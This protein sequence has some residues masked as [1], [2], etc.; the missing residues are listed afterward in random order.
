MML[1]TLTSFILLVFFLLFVSGLLRAQVREKLPEK[2]SDQSDWCINCHRSITPG[3]VASWEKSVHSRIS[4][5]EAMKKEGLKRKV[6]AEQLPED[7]KSVVVGCYECHG[8]RGEEHSDHFDHHGASIN[9]IVSP[10]DCASC[11]PVEASQF[12]ESKKAHA[13]DNLVKNEVFEQ[14][15]EAVI[16][17]SDA[18]V[19]ASTRRYTCEACHGS[20]VSVTGTRVVKR[21]MPVELP[22]LSNWPN[23]G[24]GRINPDG[25]RGACTA[26]HPRHSFSIE[27]ARKPHTCSQ[28]HLA[29]DF[30]AWEVYR[31]SKHGNI[32]LSK[33]REMNW[34]EVPWRVGKDFTAPSCASCHI[35]LVAG[36]RGK[37]LIDRSHNPASRLWIRLAGFVYSHP[38][39]K[40]GK[41][42]TIRNA[43]GKQ[44]P[45]TLDGRLAS[46][47]LIDEDEMELRQEK[48]EELCTACH[49][50]NWTEGHFA[51]MDEAIEE[52][53]AEVKAMT[54]LLQAAWSRA[55]LDEGNPFDEPLEYSWVRT[56]LYYANSI[57]Y[58]AAM[59]GPDY[60]SFKNG[61][62]EISDLMSKMKEE[63]EER[64]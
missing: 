43:Q 41:T 13:R 4:P 62:A 55:R 21:G 19:D 45:A 24:V 14:L 29:P 23:Q 12:G 57:R 8:L 50:T 31:E 61:W 3:I 56:W 47:Y 34:S 40:T 35:S 22:V 54:D 25:S 17:G 2:T 30:P 33:E 6:S 42:H 20:K 27:V 11:H 15:S 49:S 44:L 63:L 53:D 64:Q 26:C 59:S 10:D 18:K 58:G 9:V 1:R 46:Q 37:K 5:I 39:T 7:L 36:Y 28:C 32:L 60:T 16:A 48:M 52:S 51:L 38:Q